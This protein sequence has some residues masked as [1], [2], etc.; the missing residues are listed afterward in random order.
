VFVL[1]ECQVAS[2]KRLAQLINRIRRS[3]HRK[4]AFPWQRRRL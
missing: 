1:W 2:T 3:G 4:A